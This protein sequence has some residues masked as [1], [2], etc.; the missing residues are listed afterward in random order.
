MKKLLS[1]STL[2]FVL[3]FAISAKADF[4]GSVQN[5]GGF[6]GPEMAAVSVADAL[7]MSD[8]AA[9]VLEGKIEKSLGNE[10]YIFTDSTGSITVE[11]DD[12]QW[13]GV[14]VTPEDMV[15]IKGEV[16]KDMFKTEVE[17]DSV[18]LK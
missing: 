10:E 11:I 4:K 17:A 7:N 14:T 5:S 18:R 3:V 1:V 13:R 12:D 9:I 8:D 2:A 15:V 16:E 6:K